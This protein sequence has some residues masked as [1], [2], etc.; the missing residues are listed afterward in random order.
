MV[1]T[2]GGVGKGGLVGLDVLSKKR[3]RIKTMWDARDAYLILILGD[4]EVD[5]LSSSTSVHLLR[6]RYT[7]D[8]VRLTEYA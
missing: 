2:P 6:G 5:G 8:C 7:V 1:L 3:S 4:G